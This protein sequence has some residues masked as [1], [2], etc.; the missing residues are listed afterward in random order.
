[1]SYFR[2]FQTTSHLPERLRSCTPRLRHNLGLEAKH[3][4]NSINN[5]VESFCEAALEVLGSSPHL[6]SQPLKASERCLGLA[7]VFVCVCVFA[8]VAEMG[9]L[10]VKKRVW[11]HN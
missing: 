3:Q 2:G 1:M 11:K 5:G 10:R 4:L 9:D 7:C 6:T 8:R